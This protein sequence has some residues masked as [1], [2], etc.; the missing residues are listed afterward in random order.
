[1]IDRIERITAASLAERLAATD[2]P[3]LIDVRAPGEWQERRIAAAVNLPLSRLPEHTA[4]LPRDHPIVVYCATGYRSA[5]AAS[6][7]QRDGFADV[8]D[9]V[10]GFPAWESTPRAELADR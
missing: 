9:L 1:L 10:G 6:F 4:T 8:A 2:P 7:L 5:I 3:L